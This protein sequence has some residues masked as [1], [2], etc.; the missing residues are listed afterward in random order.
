[1]T[2]HPPAVAFVANS[3]TGKTTLLEKVIDELKRRGRRVGALKHDAHDFDIDHPGKDSYRFTAAGA[4]VTVIASEAKIAVVAKAGPEHSLDKI[5]SLWL[6]GM[7]LVLVEGY[8]TSDLP[9]VEVHRAALGL[10]LLTRGEHDDPHLVAVVSDETL[11]LDV[12]C[13]DLNR[14]ADVADFLEANFL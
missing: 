11:A 14:P 2:G 8:R 7:D 3:G 12:P 10:P 13:L 1:M 4:D 9:K 6:S 5:L